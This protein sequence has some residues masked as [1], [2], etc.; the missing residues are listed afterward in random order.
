M[1]F[2][3]I[4]VKDSYYN[5]NSSVMSKPVV[6]TPTHIKKTVD[7]NSPSYKD[8]LPINNKLDLNVSGTIKLTTDKGGNSVD[9][10]LTKLLSN[11]E[12]VSKLTEVITNRLSEN[13]NGGR[14]DKNSFKTITHSSGRREMN[15]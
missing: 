11:S 2:D 5:S 6:G 9:I 10:D 1:L 15:G 13:A 14:L 3:N 8:N 12:F 7:F 4:L